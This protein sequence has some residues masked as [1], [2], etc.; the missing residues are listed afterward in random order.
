MSELCQ[1]RLGGVHRRVNGIERQAKKKRLGFVSLDESHRLACQGVRQVLPLLDRGCAPQDGRALV[2]K[3]RVSS[4][5]ETEE[6]IETAPLRMKRRGA[7]QV[8]LTDQS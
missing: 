6:L 4:A 7:A 2:G 8:P 5:Q 3:V 1:P